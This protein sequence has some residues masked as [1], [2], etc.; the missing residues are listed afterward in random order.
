MSL[1]DTAVPVTFL[2][3]VVWA[4]AFGVPPS[5]CFFAGVLAGGYVSFWESRSRRLAAFYHRV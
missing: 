2:G 3:A 5:V 1:P 4:S